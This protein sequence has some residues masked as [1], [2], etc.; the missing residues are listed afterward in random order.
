MKK[1]YLIIL[2]LILTLIIAGWSAYWIV[3][4]SVVEGR[5]L[6]WIDNQSEFGVFVDFKT[7]N[8]QGYPTKLTVKVV[9]L[10][11][12]DALSG[13]KISGEQL[14]A[15]L[16]PL[17]Y[18]QV[19]LRP[20]G[21]FLFDR[22]NRPHTFEFGDHSTVTIKKRT[23]SSIE[24]EAHSKNLSWDS[25]DYEP[26]NFSG[27]DIFVTLPLN[28]NRIQIQSKAERIEL[29]NE[30][31]VLPCIGKTTINN[32]LD[33]ELGNVWQNSPNVQD[34]E[35]FI[36]GGTSINVKSL[37]YSHGA[38]HVQAK[39]D[40]TIGT[41]GHLNG[42]IDFRIDRGDELLKIL[43]G[44]CMQGV[45]RSSETRFVLSALNSG[46]ANGN[47]L[48][49]AVQNGEVKLFGFNIYEFPRVL[50]LEGL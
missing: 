27:V 7:L 43:S 1:L 21:V 40:L 42:T 50:P 41:R 14:I 36:G 17:D 30:L 3:V 31:G 13:I 10:S 29:Q 15:S 49:L 32:Q 11:Y 4:R 9:E 37:K 48:K 12:D 26:M 5:I 38:M 28:E 33:L 18:S 24:V 44:P 35:L 23:D 19:H 25:V 20:I 45:P 46:S 6:A 2:T 47:Y 22:G 16:N 34:R 39:S 8:F